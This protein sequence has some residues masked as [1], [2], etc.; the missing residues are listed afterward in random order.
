M[1]EANYLLKNKLIRVTVNNVFG[2]KKSHEM[3]LNKHKG[4]G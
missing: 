4:H 3:M 1:V 2:G